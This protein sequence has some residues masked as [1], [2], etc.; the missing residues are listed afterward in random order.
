MILTRLHLIDFKSIVTAS[1]DFS[2]KVNCFIGLNGMGKTNMLDALHYLSFTKSHLAITDTLAVRRGQERALLEGT[3]QSDHGDERHLLLQIRPG[4]RKVLKRNR[5]EYTRLSEH[6]GAFPL[7]IASPQDYQLI[8]GGSE[9]RRRFVDRQLSQ[10]D[11]VYMAALAQYHRVLEQRNTLL[12][13]P[14]TPSP[15]VLD[16]LDLQLEQVSP[17]IYDRRKRF[18]EQFVPLFQRYYTA[19]SGG[20]EQ[21]SL[22]YVSPLESTEGH[23]ADLLR[24]SRDRDRILGHTSVGLH[25]DDLLMLLDGEL[26]RRIGSEGQNKTYLLALKFAQYTLLAETNPERPLLLLDDIFD[27]LD[28]ERV[29]RIIHLVGGS[30]FG[31][32]FITDT[33]REHLDELVSSWGR[34]YR[35]FEVVEGALHLIA[36]QAD[37]AK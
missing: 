20:Q 1:C 26:I 10:Q 11:S 6:I 23:I 18:V 21:V 17:M 30:D 36:E 3:Y 37:E 2:P 34:D 24:E 7:V 25:R 32:I 9:E 19:I 15:S 27:K 31:Q 35:L 22:S 16:V 13:A 8:L 33:N 4:A 12:K 14:S 28:A 5:K 29:A